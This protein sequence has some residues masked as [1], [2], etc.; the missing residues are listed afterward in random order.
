MILKS[1]ITGVL[2]V[3][4]SITSTQAQLLKKLKNTVN[5]TI[6]ELANDAVE[7]ELSLGTATI[8]HESFG[9]TNV[10]VVRE[11]KV[12]KYNESTLIT[13]SWRT[14]EAD[15]FDGYSLEIGEAKENLPGT[16]EI[17]ATNKFKIGYD[18]SSTTLNVGPAVSGDYLNLEFISGE[19]TIAFAEVSSFS[20]SFKGTAKSDGKEVSVNGT[21][22]TEQVE[23]YDNRAYSSKKSTSSEDNSSAYSNYSSYGS[24][25]SSNEAS[26]IRATYKFV[27]KVVHEVK[28]DQSKDI[29]K[30]SY[31]FSNED[32]SGISV[33]M[34]DYG[35]QG[36][37]FIV[38]DNGE[39][40]MFIDAGGMKMRMSQMPGGAMPMPDQEFSNP[41]GT[42]FKKSGATKTILGYNCEEYIVKDEHTDSRFWVTTDLK[43]KNWMNFPENDIQG[44]ILEYNIKSKDGN[45]TSIATEI[46]TSANIVINSSEYRKGF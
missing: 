37:S 36:E 41:N 42:E 2:V 14:H 5:N 20:M 45:M 28:T 13:G 35:Q 43:I 7:E 27:Q 32:Y 16:Y 15:I 31:L 39:T 25:G 6:N 23:I 44:H 17:G 30:M 3:L 11:T 38:M 18:P 26:K 10:E 8:N 1:I 24:S 22:T 9:K 34:S 12:T 21:I 40:H 4:C 19:V 33:N 29:I 46:N